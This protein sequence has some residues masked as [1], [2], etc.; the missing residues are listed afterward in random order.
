MDFEAADERLQRL[1]ERL[2]G[3][4]DR[5]WIEVW[6]EWIG[7]AKTALE[8][9]GTSAS[10]GIWRRQTV[11]DPRNG[12]PIEAVGGDARGLFLEA[13]GAS[14]YLPWSA[15]G[16][17]PDALHQLFHARLTR[18]WSAEEKKHIAGLLRVSAVAAAWTPLEKA[19]RSG[20]APG[21]RDRRGID[22]SFEDALQWGKESGSLALVSAERAAIENLLEA[23]VAR[24]QGNATLA[25]HA[26]EE[27][28]EKH[29]DTL[30]LRV[31][32]D[33]REWRADP[34]EVAAVDASQDEPAKDEGSP[35]DPD[36]Q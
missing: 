9:V 24:E 22:A 32:S 12:R 11:L 31:L 5:A 30:V 3:E 27:A 10:S 4:E 14:E 34:V 1:Q 7:G 26:L 25:I 20:S 36:D 21:D 23:L 35:G 8:T 6:R 29:A 18:D 19:L 33:G 15:W 13:S 2:S 16:A 28:F 17:H